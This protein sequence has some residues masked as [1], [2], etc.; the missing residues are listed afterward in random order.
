MLGHFRLATVP[1]S[2]TAG[3]GVLLLLVRGVLRSLRHLG[4]VNPVSTQYYLQFTPE[5]RPS[6]S[7]RFHR[8][9]AYLFTVGAI[10]YDAAKA[11]KP[12][13]PVTAP[14]SP[15]TCLGSESSVS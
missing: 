6:A 12:R 7:Q 14:S 4:H 3:F 11:L 13:L 10:L 1:S 9:F 15:A 5:L 8:H 2:R